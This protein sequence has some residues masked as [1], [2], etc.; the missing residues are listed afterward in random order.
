MLPPPSLVRLRLLFLTVV[1]GSTFGGY[2]FLV[3]GRESW[4]AANRVCAEA[5]QV[6]TDGITALL[7]C[8][9][10]L[11]LQQSLVP[12]AGPALVALL[13]VV[14]YLAAPRLLERREHAWRW[15]DPPPEVTSI[16]TAADLPRTPTLMI[17]TRARRASPLAYGRAR[18]H[19]IMLP[20]AFPLR[21]AKGSAASAV[22][23][24]HE[25]GHL[26][27]R[28]VDRSYLAVFSVLLFVPVVAA[29]V[30]VAASAWNEAFD[31]SL[32]WR[33][34][35]LTVL[36]G[37]TFVA[38]LRAREHD[39]D[40]WA[41]RAMGAEVTRVVK[42]ASAERSWW[43]RLHPTIE[44]RRKVL[45][46]P[47]LTMRASVAESFGTGLAAGVVILELSV[48]AET[49]LPIEPVLAYW[50]AA[51]PITVTMT[52][53]VGLAVWRATARSEAEGNAINNANNAGATD[54][55]EPGHTTTGGSPS[56]PSSPSSPIWPGSPG[57]PS[58]GRAGRAGRLRRPPDGFLGP[59]LALG[60]GLVA[61]A[62]AAPRAAAQWNV[63]SP[64]ASERAATLNILDAA[65]A[66]AVALALSLPLTTALIVWWLAV[67]AKSWLRRWGAGS[68]RFAV[69]VAA[70][71]SAIPVGTWFL[72]ARLA[73]AETWRPGA[74][75]AQ[76]LSTEA[77]YGL[78]AAPVACWV[79]VC[80]GQG[81][82]RPGRRP[83]RLDQ[84]AAS[85]GEGTA[86]VNR[87]TTD[88]RPARF[89]RGT[90]DQG[91][92]RFDR[93]PG[94]R[95]FSLAAGGV[96]AVLLAVPAVVVAGWGSAVPSAPDP[97]PPSSQPVAG[98]LWLRT[99]GVRALGGDRDHGARLRLGNEL[100]GLEDALLRQAG[101]LFV[102]SSRERS[103]D[104]ARR[105]WRAFVRRC[106]HLLRYPPPTPR[107]PEV[108]VPFPFLEE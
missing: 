58:A 14:A 87:R 92:A 33:L 43:I 36:T 73:A 48:L 68:W 23:L 41:R 13:T 49:A 79:A 103:G 25:L 104:M 1:A 60:V 101:A 56:S 40:L 82:A 28:D 8:T 98:C 4:P 96:L 16:V 108:K 12:M 65:P 93:G 44:E 46:R 70:V 66:T 84:G 7:D 37:A 95:I 27:N 75:A 38:V 76:V 30:V 35:V 26:R 69:P 63:V 100:S 29:P 77:G 3:L 91:T 54:T 86:R 24:L 97:F 2:V 15:A 34:A 74:L 19:R 53:I 57:S 89:N 62:L 9:D 102:R 31:W 45:E 21:M 90:A 99:A 52:G 85:P 64:A 47:G 83:T 50:L 6:A 32:C 94:A 59:G 51:L 107:A 80:L 81:T 106:D 55:T 17:S 105:A 61:G 20:T 88:Q 72:A 5:S 10:R 18:A 39:A 67:L 78:A 11:H 71:V 42:A 22:S